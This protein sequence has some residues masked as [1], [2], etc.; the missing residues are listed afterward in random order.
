LQRPE[1]EV[2]R[3]IL[4]AALSSG[5]LAATVLADAP[6]FSVGVPNHARG[7]AFP[8]AQILNGYG[9]TGGNRSPPLAW[10]H[11][12]AGTKS[13]AVTMFDP[14]EKA[15]PSGWWHWVVY[16]IPATATGLP[17]N[18]GVEKSSTLPKGSIQGRTDLGNAAY[19][20]PCPGAGET[21][22][23]YRITVY[24]LSAPKLDVPAEAS[25]AMVTYA[26]HDQTLATAVITVRHGR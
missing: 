24:A 2:K 26:A 3:M 18:A 21:P 14:D 6:K 16:D 17:E 22:H 13:F 5:A 25:G 10:T 20:G 1:V 19:H 12:P 9:C 23:R 8:V 11:V 15:T 7:Q 4:F